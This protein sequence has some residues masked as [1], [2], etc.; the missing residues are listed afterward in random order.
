MRR[1]PEDELTFI[2]G[3]D[4]AHSLPTWREPEAVLALPTLGVAEREGVA[5]RPTS[6][7][8]LAGLRRRRT[9]SASSTC[10]ASTSP[11]R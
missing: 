10:P 3:G 5:P 8:R 11:P 9:G 2:V 1:S 7:E 6:R 4:M